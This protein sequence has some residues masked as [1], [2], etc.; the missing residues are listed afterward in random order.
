MNEIEEAF[1]NDLRTKVYQYIYRSME[2]PFDLLMQ[3]IQ[4][5][6][7]STLNWHREENKERLKRIFNNW[8]TAVDGYTLENGDFR[9][10]ML[11]AAVNIV[12]TEY[13]SEL[14]KLYLNQSYDVLPEHIVNAL[15]GNYT[16]PIPQNSNFPGTSNT[17]SEM[18]PAALPLIPNTLYTTDII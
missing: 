9:S 10:Y 13:R 4:I 18:S 7:G 2:N 11:L 12:C 17:S 16:P 15:D 5:A 6:S 1:L 14:F 3:T 8:G